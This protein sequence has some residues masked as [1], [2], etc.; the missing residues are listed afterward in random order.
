MTN[1]V[2]INYIVSIYCFVWCAPC[3]VFI[4]YSALDWGKTKM[5]NNKSST[6]DK[7]E[8][9]QICNCSIC[10]KEFT[11]VLNCHHRFTNQ[12]Q[13][14]MFTIYFSK[15]KCRNGTCCSICGLTHLKT[16]GSVPSV[17]NSSQASRIYVNIFVFI[18]V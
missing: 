4:S 1:S 14:V 8:N 2:H 10:N 16:S 11:Q 15:L 3:A 9:Y 6:E 7:V 17:T 18:L 12:N 13:I 5:S